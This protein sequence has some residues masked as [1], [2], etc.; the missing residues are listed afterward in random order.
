MIMNKSKTHPL[1][2]TARSRLPV[3]ATLAAGVA[4]LGSA[5][6]GA[7]I[8]QTVDQASGGTS[9]NW[10]EAVWGDPAASPTSGNDYVSDGMTLRTNNNSGTTTFAGDTLTMINSTLIF[11][12]SS[13]A[14]FILDGAT[15]SAVTNGAIDGTMLLAAGKTATFDTNGRLPSLTATLS[16]SGTFTKSGAGTLTVTNAANTFTGTWVVTQD[17][18]T[19][20]T[21]G[22]FDTV[23]TFDVTGGL[24]DIG[25][26]FNGTD[27]NLTLGGTGTFDLS[28]GFNH[29]FASVSIA[30][31]TLAAGT[32]SYGD[33]DAAQQ[34]FFVSGADTFTVA[35]A[36]IPE[37]STYAL[38]GGIGTLLFACRHR[39]KSAPAGA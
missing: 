36:T 4:L 21:A 34:A 22:S 14:N 23:G 18:L 27:T 26:A 2:R 6:H 9:T 20:S 24:L 30:G 8:F 15:F 28:N 17:I 3:L 33:L 13:R 25:Y 16:G 31:T 7:T 10:S 19:S 29:T 11:R 37:P 32:Y 35:G 38:L 12:R 1:P 5:L 39:R